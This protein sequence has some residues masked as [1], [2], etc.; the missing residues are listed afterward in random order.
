M[1]EEDKEEDGADEALPSR[2]FLFW[3]DA[4]KRE[5]QRINSK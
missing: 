2:P 4:T 5:R 3:F 1:E